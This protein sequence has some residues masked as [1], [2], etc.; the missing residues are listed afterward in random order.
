M[1]RSISTSLVSE[2]KRD[3]P[4]T[5]YLFPFWTGRGTFRVGDQTYEF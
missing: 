5:E 3:Y 4:F 2:I 1:L